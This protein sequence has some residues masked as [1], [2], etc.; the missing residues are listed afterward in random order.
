M[1]QFHLNTPLHEKDVRQLR[2]GD[3]VL[4]SGPVYTARDAAHKRFIEL[5]DRG[6]NL[7]F[8]TEGAVVYYV[9]PTPPPPGRPIGSAGPT[10]SSRMDAY[11]PRLHSLGVRA[12]IGKGKRDASVR[13]ALSTYGGVYLGA[14]GGTGALISTHVTASR[15][16]AFADLGTE[17]V[18]ELTLDALP[19]LVINDSVGGS[20]YV[21]PI[22]K[23][24][25]LE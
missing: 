13:A 19:L 7:P 9:G 15:L 21:T 20:L 17:A 2:A 11:A 1:T 4:L 5:L 12:T 18:R 16:I 23:A 10:T 25:G 14:T 3:L 22:M 24:V 6:E 8:T